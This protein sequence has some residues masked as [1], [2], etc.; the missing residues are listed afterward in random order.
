VGQRPIIEKYNLERFVL[1][2]F[3]QGKSSNAIKDA[4]AKERGIVVSQ[5]AVLTFL[6]QNKLGGIKPL[7]R[8]YKGAQELIAEAQDAY[9]ELRKK[10]LKTNNIRDQV[11]IWNEVRNWWDRLARIQ[12][13]MHPDQTNIQINITGEYEEFKRAVLDV[14]SDHPDVMDKLEK[15]LLHGP[16]APIDA[17][18]TR[19]EGL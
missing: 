16:N 9:V 18:A 13:L 4:I 3:A 12:G 1:D 7:D 11:F 8:S 15:R 19:T 2:H 5:K 14:L 10:A 6:N 17:T